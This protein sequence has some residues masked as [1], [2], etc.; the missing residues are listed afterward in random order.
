MKKKKNGSITE[1]LEFCE[2][3]RRFTDYHR[4]L[5]MHMI[6]NSK[7]PAYIMSTMYSIH[8][9]LGT[10]ERD[11]VKSYGKKNEEGKNGKY[12]DRKGK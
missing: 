4:K 8:I 9:S 10:F 12:G 5:L 7:S 3:L 1:D 2:L 6:V 11:I